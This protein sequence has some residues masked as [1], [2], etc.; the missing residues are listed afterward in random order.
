MR[1]KGGGRI[2]FSCFETEIT[3]TE[4]TE[5]S[6]KKLYSV[7]CIHFPKNETVNCQLSTRGFT[8]IRLYKIFDNIGVY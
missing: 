8:N 6:R 1:S 5:T 4:I 2:S 3:E 7:F